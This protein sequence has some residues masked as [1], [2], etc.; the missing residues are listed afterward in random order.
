[1]VYIV[2]GLLYGTI[3]LY[4]LLS[5]ALIWGTYVAVK[6]EQKRLADLSKDKL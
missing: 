1:M 3:P 6:D 2:I 5:I 4:I